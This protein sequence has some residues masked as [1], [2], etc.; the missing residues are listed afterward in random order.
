[1][2]HSNAAFNKYRS[3]YNVVLQLVT[4]QSSQLFWISLK[5]LCQSKQTNAAV[6]KSR[7]ITEILPT[8]FCANWAYMRCPALIYTRYAR[9]WREY[10]IK[11]Y[12][13][14]KM[15]SYSISGGGGLPPPPGPGGGNHVT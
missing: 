4:S 12:S 1:M 5:D 3:N 9:D 15:I 2:F 8:D 6:S 7:N 14:L 13:S 11:L 10:L